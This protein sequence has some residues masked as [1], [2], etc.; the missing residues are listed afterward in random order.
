M[1]SEIIEDV[2]SALPGLADEYVQVFVSNSHV[3]APGCAHPRSS[4]SGPRTMTMRELASCKFSTC[5]EEAE[6]ACFWDCSQVARARRSELLG[7]AVEKALFS[8]LAH[9]S[10]R[11]SKIFLPFKDDFA[12][13]EEVYNFAGELELD[14]KFSLPDTASEVIISKVASRREEILERVISLDAPLGLQLRCLSRD[15]RRVELLVESLTADPIFNL[16]PGHFVRRADKL[17]GDILS[18]ASPDVEEVFRKLHDDGF[19]CALDDAEMRKVC[20][21]VLELATEQIPDEKCLVFQGFVSEPSYGLLYQLWPR[22]DCP[23]FFGSVLLVP[24]I[25]AES[26]YENSWS[27]YGSKGPSVR[28]SE[29]GIIPVG[30]ASLGV[31][32]TAVRLWAEA[33]GG[34]YSTGL[35]AFEAALVL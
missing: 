18:F 29:F 6:F 25:V 32:E 3:H 23:D 15:P 11:M 9:T 12:Y 24:R 13:L 27:S 28:Q 10:A 21:L 30:D 14:I 16:L 19:Y 20:S 17:V 2:L 22:Y 8:M 31:I 7:Y 26:L 33:R 4:D 1:L 34:V 5:A 35:A